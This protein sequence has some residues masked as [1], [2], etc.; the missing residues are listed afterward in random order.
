MSR[1]LRGSLGTAQRPK[2][3]SMLDRTE[4]A[5]RKNKELDIILSFGAAEYVFL[6]RAL[7]S[8]TL[9]YDG[10]QAVGPIYAK[11]P[12]LDWTQMLGK[13]AL[14]YFLERLLEAKLLQER[15]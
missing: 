14:L 5:S 4:M 9:G 2:K 13:Q 6:P 12:I 15:G 7:Y 10:D 11:L 8:S 3:S 1:I